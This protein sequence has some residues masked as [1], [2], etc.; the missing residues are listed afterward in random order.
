M[1]TQFLLGFVAG[2]Y[3]AQNYDMPNVKNLMNK[4]FQ[5]LREWEGSNGGGR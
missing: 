4:G 5:A 3:M 2:V 1:G